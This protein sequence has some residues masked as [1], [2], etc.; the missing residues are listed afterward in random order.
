MFTI[1]L[2]HIGVSNQGDSDFIMLLS[3]H[4]QYFNAGLRNKVGQFGTDAADAASAA[5]A[6]GA[7]G[8][9]SI[10]A[11]IRNIIFFNGP[12]V[13]VQPHDLHSSSSQTL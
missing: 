11:T 4:G 9:I 13:N 2:L 7:A 10:T 6:T 12:I 3:Q 1:H 5:G 8:I